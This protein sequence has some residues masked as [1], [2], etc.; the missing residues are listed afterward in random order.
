TRQ[1]PHP[2]NP[3]CHLGEPK[4]KERKVG[5]AELL[6]SA[7]CYLKEGFATI[8]EEVPYIKGGKQNET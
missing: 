8:Y 6:L 1:P 2:R 3:L 5:G 7:R 4:R